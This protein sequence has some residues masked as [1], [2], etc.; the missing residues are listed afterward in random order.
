MPRDAPLALCTCVLLMVAVLA[1]GLPPAGSRRRLLRSTGGPSVPPAAS[2]QRKRSRGRPEPQ[3]TLLN[4]ALAAD[5]LSAALRAGSPLATALTAVGEALPPAR[6]AGTGSLGSELASAGRS[7]LLGATLEH[8]L[9]PLR[10][11]AARPAH[12]PRPR[13]RLT[14]DGEPHA[15]LA[16][17]LLR[18]S[19]SG[20]R[21]AEQLGLL[22]DDA[23]ARAAAESLA[24]ARRLGVLAVLP[25]GGCFLPAF[26]LLAV[27]P[28]V[29]G[30][31]SVVAG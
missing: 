13:Q 30:L 8:A 10:P 23:R 19:A 2:V 26:M 24:G 18:S 20:A 16:A 17:V 29:A 28:T 7:L 12:W 27:V 9:D 22:A 15:Q 4:A 14:R 6:S 1:T 3:A 5:L 25:L 11:A 31:V 21:L